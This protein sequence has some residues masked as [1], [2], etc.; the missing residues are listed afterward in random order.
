[1]R[2]ARG[3][4]SW[5]LMVGAGRDPAAIQ[6]LV[7]RLVDSG[8]DSNVLTRV[9]LAVGRGLKR[10][11]GSPA[12]VMEGPASGRIA[13]LL[14][15]AA[16]VAQGDGPIDRRLPAIAL[17]AMGEPARALKVLPELA[18]LSPARP[19]PARGT[20]GPGRTRRPVGGPARAGPVEVDEPG[21]SG[22]RPPRS[23]SAVATGSRACSPRSSRRPSC[24][25]R[26]TPIGQA[27][28]DASRTRR[29]GPGP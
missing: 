23:C 1:M 22:A 29:F 28:P 5:P 3:S 7:A 13:A 26:S 18:R 6:R 9:V 27:A 11:G 15:E 8:V 14:A 16:Q 2:A 17:L 10:T 19:G 12:S 21:R 20:T 25:A 24:R 4:T